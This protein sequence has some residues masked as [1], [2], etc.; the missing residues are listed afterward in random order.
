MSA[1]DRPDN[2]FQDLQ[3]APTRGFFPILW[4]RKA[5]IILGVL[6]GLAGGFLA[7]WQRPP[8]YQSTALV[9]VIK[10]NNQPLHVLNDPRLPF[11]EDYMGTH[12]V[13]LKSP[14]IIEKAV[15]KKDLASLR[16]FEGSG[17]PVG[18]ILNSLT[19]SRDIKEL[20]GGSSNANNIVYLAY[21]GPVADE[22][23]KILTAIIESYQE[24]LDI[25]YRNVSDQSLDLITKARDVLSKD[26]K[27]AEEKHRSFLLN[28]KTP[29]FMRNKDGGNL[30][31]DRM[32]ELEKRRSLQII[33]MEELKERI[34]AL[35]EA[36][37]EGKGSDTLI[38]LLRAGD[39]K[40]GAIV[41]EKT[42]NE[43]L[44]PLRA[45]ERKLLLTYEADHPSVKGVRA[46]MELIEDLHKKLAGGATEAA[47][48]DPAKHFLSV[49]RAEFK[50]AEVVFNSL[51]AIL[52]G[53]KS[54][55]KTMSKD[56]LEEEQY[57]NEVTRLKAFYEGTIKRLS[58]LNFNRESGGF[59]AS[60][61]S[62]P[63]IGV[64]IA[65]SAFQMIVGG[66]MLGLL[67][68]IGLAFL[69][70][71]TD[72]GIR[73]PDEVR[74]RLNLPLL[75]H[76]PFLRPDPE[77]AR[78]VEAGEL[79]TDPL[80]HAMYRPKS[81]EA[82]AY[83]A[84]RTA[85]LF[86]IQGEGHRVIQVTSPNKGDGK[87]LM[88]SNLA[89][90]IAQA[91]KRVLLI[92]ADCRRPRQ[93]QIF[94]LV[95]NQGLVNVVR[96]EQP[97]DVCACPSGQEGLWILPSGPVPPNPAELLASPLFTQFLE[98]ARQEFDLVLVDSPPLLAVTDPCIVAGRMDGV[99][100]TLRLSR[101]GRP[102]AERACE[103]MKSL[104]VNVYG[105][106]VNGVT[107]QLGG[108]LYT[109][110]QYDYTES[111]TDNDTAGQED[112][113]YYHYAEESSDA[114]APTP[115]VP[116]EAKKAGAGLLSRIF[117]RKT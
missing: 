51:G 88:I 26:L 114:S 42:M 2:E 38:A 69:A 25:K 33:R 5:L 58:E 47:E 17:D 75:G 90:S 106:V 111:Y 29:L 83:R 98:T 43:Q 68:G 62:P 86:R 71:F 80:L 107:R 41:P 12:V 37:K 8:V 56:E 57:R 27:Q 84:I 40:A 49:M 89:I 61:L 44:L 4:Q 63:G 20:V 94:N 53:L 28:A 79:Q 18:T 34:K 50:E 64:K 101:Q 13:L 60:P 103:I 77:T 99:I 21:R 59:D 113:Y 109:S 115:N 10:K 45:E 70:D 112:A 16:A 108:G 3:V 30:T 14:M 6:L 74:R 9:L 117:S 102:Q 54:E 76:V 96:Q 52:E 22:C 82:E 104:K 24:F 91:G 15:K 19:V 97:W 32:G 31:L 65:P 23:G 110:E 85:L 87:S 95:N 92:D 1:T 81:L 55:A 36:I 93:H 46:H 78:K 48:R 72:K 73:S 67:A 100:L 116:V 11:L 35:D 7:Y 39:S 66:L 105:V